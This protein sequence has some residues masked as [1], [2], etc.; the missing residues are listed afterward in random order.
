MHLYRT[1]GGMALVIASVGVAVAA[2]GDAATS[3]GDGNTASL[4]VQVITE[5]NLQGTWMDSE[6]ADPYTSRWTFAKPNMTFAKY[7]GRVIQTTYTLKGNTLIVHH[8]PGLVNK[9]PWDETIEL[10][11]YSGDTLTWDYGTLVTLHRVR[12]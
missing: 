3:T 9:D 12:N 11:H 4:Q 10:K 8:A 1:I 2:N 5:D 6:S 7:N